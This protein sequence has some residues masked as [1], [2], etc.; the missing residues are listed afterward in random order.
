MLFN[1][2]FDIYQILGNKSHLRTHGQRLRR[3]PLGRFRAC[4]KFHQSA[5]SGK[6]CFR[7]SLSRTCSGADWLRRIF[8]FCRDS[9][10][11]SWNRR[12]DV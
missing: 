3:F 9:R 5:T 7:Q 1:Y 2:F 8:D 6:F 4:S 12:F 10:Q 11:L